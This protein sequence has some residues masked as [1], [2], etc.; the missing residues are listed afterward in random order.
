MWK[1]SEIGDDSIFANPSRAYLVN[2][3]SNNFSYKVMHT[4]HIVCV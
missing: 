1:E 3:K 4:D 2:Q